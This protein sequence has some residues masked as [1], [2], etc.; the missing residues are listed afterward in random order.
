MSDSLNDWG[1]PAATAAD[2]Q[3]GIPIVLEAGDIFKRFVT[4]HTAECVGTRRAP[5]PGAHLLNLFLSPHRFCVRLHICFLFFFSIFM[6]ACRQHMEDRWAVATSQGVMVVGVFDGHGGAAVSSALKHLPRALLE[7]LL[8]VQ[9]R[10][11]GAK[12]RLA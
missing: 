8:K 1:L 11:S 10:T 7:E 4:I 5:A 6:S 9:H 12:A 2:V 3:L